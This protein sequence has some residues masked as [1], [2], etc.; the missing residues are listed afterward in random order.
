MSFYQGHVKF[1]FNFIV[2]CRDECTH[3]DSREQVWSGSVEA[4]SIFL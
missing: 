1:I 3:V 2:V 4:A